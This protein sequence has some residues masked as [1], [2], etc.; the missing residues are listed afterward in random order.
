M[1]PNR[2]VKDFFMEEFN[3]TE[4][5]QNSVATSAEKTDNTKVEPKKEV[6]MHTYYWSNEDVPFRVL[7]TADE[8]TSNQYPIVVTAPDPNLKAPKYD[9]MKQEWIETSEESLGQRLTTVVEQLEDAQK[10][11]DVLQEAHQTTL[12]NTK[13]TDTA[14]GQLQ[15]TV[16]MSNRMMATLSATVSALAKAYQGL[17]S[18]DTTTETN[19]GDAK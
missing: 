11:I 17:K 8:I 19:Q 18:P 15:K 6:V 10:S 14:M 16:Q 12:K 13:S 5:T 1:I 3:M 7:R 2:L 4:E 9:W